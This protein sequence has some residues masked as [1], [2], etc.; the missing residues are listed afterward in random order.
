M[1][2]TS[3]A[4]DGIRAI[5][6]TSP[7]LDGGEWDPGVDYVPGQVVAN[8]GEPFVALLPS[9][10]IEPVYYPDGDPEAVARVFSIDSVNNIAGGWATG[11]LAAPLEVDEA[12]D[13]E[14]I[15]WHIQGTAGPGPEFG[16]NPR[17]EIRLDSYDGTV[18]GLASPGTLTFDDPSDIVTAPLAQVA[19]LVPGQRYWITWHACAR[20]MDQGNALA[21]NT[22]ITWPTDD[23]E[24][25]PIPPRFGGDAY[26][27]VAGNGYS[28]PA[29]Q[30]LSV[31]QPYEACWQRLGPPQAIAADR[32]KML[33]QQN[34]ES[35]EDKLFIGIRLANGL[36]GWQELS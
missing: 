29:Y 25:G 7:D 28:Q 17:L 4:T 19:T 14:K 1:P 27:S 36:H 21:E 32:G 23:P 8:D 34:P 33:L 24:I 5:G 15:T 22:H 31:P 16:V 3:G 12:I 30:L 11:W 9:T 26:G 18:H 6:A 10:G 35:L 13:V 20:H 2:F